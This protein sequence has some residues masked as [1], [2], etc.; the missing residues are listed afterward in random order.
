[1]ARVSHLWATARPSY[2]RSFPRAF[3]FRNWAVPMLG[4]RHNLG[5]PLQS[6][7]LQD[8]LG[9]D[10][11][12]AATALAAPAASHVDTPPRRVRGHHV[13][14]GQARANFPRKAPGSARP[15]RRIAVPTP[16]PHVMKTCG[17]RERATQGLAGH[18]A[19]TRTNGCLIRKFATPSQVY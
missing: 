12:A 10:P 6:V 18:T 17:P 4:R 15:F 5:R 13:P 11:T 3:R 9:H 19:R 2:F 8:F 7:P 16:V 1:M 14:T